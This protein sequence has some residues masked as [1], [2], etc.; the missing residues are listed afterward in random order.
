MRARDGNG[1]RHPLFI[2]TLAVATALPLSAQGGTWIQSPVNGHWY[3]LTPP[4]NWESTRQWAQANN[5]ELVTI[6]SAAE[7]SWLMQAIVTPHN[8]DCWI[9]LNDLQIQGQWVWSSGEAVTYTNWGGGEPNFPGVERRT[10]L[11]PSGVW[12]NQSNWTRPGIAERRAPGSFTPFGLGCVG[13]NQQTPLLAAAA[14]STPGIGRSCDI[15][16]RQLPLAVTVPIFVFGFSKTTNLGPGGWYALPF[17]LSAL[18][19]PGCHQLVSTDTTTPA[20]TTTGIAT[21][22]ITLPYLPPILGLSF[23]AQAFVLYHPTGVAVSNGLTGV[24]GY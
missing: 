15:E 5:A 13:A 20:I 8:G 17:E 19:W 4:G 2:A 18:G 9:G 14:G 10:E 22:T 12:N 11:Q 1:M 3:A 23:H 24:V 6:R 7:Q 21:T 16:V